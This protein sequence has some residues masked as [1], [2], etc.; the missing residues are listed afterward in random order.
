MSKT[1][2]DYEARLMAGL[3]EFPTAA[4]FAQI[5]DPRQLASLR[6][7][8]YMLAMADAESEI[9]AYEPFLKS[10]DMTVLADASVKGI[11][12]F[13]KP[14]RVTVRATNDSISP[15]T[16]ASGRRLLDTQ[17]RL[18]VV[19]AG[20]KIPAGGMGYVKAAQQSEREFQHTVAA[21]QSFYRI[22][23]PSAE[24]GQ[25][26]AA[27]RVRNGAGT[28]LVWKPEFMNVPDGDLSFTLETDE[29][30]VLSVVFGSAGLSGIQPAAGEVFTVIVTDTSG[31]LDLTVDSPFTFEYSNSLYESQMA[32]A[33]YSMDSKGAAPMGIDVLRTITNY[34]ALYNENAVFLGNFDYLVRKKLSPFRFLSV[35]N[36]QIEE[37]A[38]GANI[39]NIN[40]I[41]VTAISDV[42]ADPPTLQAQIREVIRRADD[43]YKIQ[44][45][46]AV[47]HEI[48]VTITAH[49][50]TVYDFVLVEQQIRELMYRWY[51]ID[52]DFAKYGRNRIQN[53][54]A[55][56]L[57]TGK[58]A[59][60]GGVLAVQ[61]KIS[62]V[63]VVINDP[64]AAIMP[65][66]Y[67]FVSPGS[68]VV[69]VYQAN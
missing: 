12:P 64:I 63:T 11:L 57:L 55:I 16:I 35:W 62:D 61:D 8:A 13:G 47:Y 14:A 20:A 26:I 3:S 54:D 31:E 28:E 18:F 48:P 15:L 44:F 69:H 45:V 49:I 4:Q 65:E 39:S 60:E 43:S 29:R 25:H 22:P 23:I 36:E 17:G 5:G 1:R 67:R 30:R 34:P 50:S 19:V 51:G 52:S 41:F 27:V 6:A 42:I 68:L 21:H 9:A 24:A 58:I 66:D 2:Q 33:F 37:D 59:G 38:R 53:K 56:N 46:P 40:T 32:L 7:M 10:R